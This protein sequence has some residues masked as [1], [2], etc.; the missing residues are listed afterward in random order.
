MSN[1]LYL[2]MVCIGTVI[3]SALYCVAA[4]V[5]HKNTKRI[6]AAK[7]EVI[8]VTAELKEMS[9]DML[10]KYDELIGLVS[11]IGPMQKSQVEMLQHLCTIYQELIDRG[12]I[13]VP[14]GNEAVYS[15][16]KLVSSFTASGFS[17]IKNN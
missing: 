3:A 10:K 17:V 12:L 2:L 14:K 4:Y 6:E 11:E 8:Q 1:S 15:L 13:V 16:N 5:T 9:S 7:S